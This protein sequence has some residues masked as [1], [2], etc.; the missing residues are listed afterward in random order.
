MLGILLLPSIVKSKPIDKFLMEALVRNARDDGIKVKIYRVTVIFSIDFM[1]VSIT[2]LNCGN[3]HYLSL[4]NIPLP[5]VVKLKAYKSTFQ[6]ILVRHAKE[7]HLNSCI[8]R[9]VVIGS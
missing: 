6:A 1:W 5:N 7:E 4:G 8:E 2:W 3:W 9:F